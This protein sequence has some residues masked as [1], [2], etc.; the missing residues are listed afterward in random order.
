MSW[1]RFFAVIISFYILVNAVFA[2]LFMLIGLEHL[3]GA[4]TDGTW[5][6]DFAAAFFFSVQTFTTVGYGAVSPAGTAANILAA[7]GALVGL[8]GF[9]LATGLFFS[10]FAKPKANIRFS[11]KATIRPYK[12]TG[13]QS[14]QFQIVNER[15][16]KVI[17]LS[18]KVTMS[19]V[20]KGPEGHKARRFAFLP[21]ER[22]EVFLFPLN[23]VIVHIIDEES[24]LWG[25]DKET[26]QEME[27]EFLALLQGFDETFAQ[28][29]HANSSYLS[30][31]VVW[32]QQFERMYWP[33]EGYTVLDLSRLD[34]LKGLGEA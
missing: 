4:Q 34:E 33:E 10:R 20:E 5:A 17:N 3:N 31:D 9:A 16:N 8:M 7:A 13:Y 29:V 21:L 6:G 18:A 30:R 12:D 19:W 23:W 25:K 15:N 2:G 22:D 26:L 11:E 24:P 14:F 32:G 28:D 27:P 1:P